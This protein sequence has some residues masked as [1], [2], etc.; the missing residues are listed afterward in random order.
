YTE[1]ET[2][3]TESTYTEPE[4]TYTESD[5]TATE[6]SVSTETTT[7][8][9][10]TSSTE[11]STSANTS[12]E[13]TSTTTTATAD[14]TTLLGALIY[15]EAGNQSYEGKVAVGAVV[16][17]RVKSSSFPNSITE[18][19]YQSGQFTP[20]YKLASV[21]AN[22]VPSACYSA[23]VDAING[24]DP[25]GGCLYFNTYS[26]TLKIGDHWFS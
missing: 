21:I 23:A 18:V 6:T 19:I 1:S 5:T 20:A 13:E 7:T 2:T 17:N 3:Y 22:G 15:L 14:E 16:M 9:E 12:T 10:T 4:T 25:T 26:G 24:S 11:T 8:T